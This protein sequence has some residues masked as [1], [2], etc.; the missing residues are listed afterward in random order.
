MNGRTRLQNAT[1]FELAAAADLRRRGWDVE[2][3]GVEL[4]SETAIG[5]LQTTPS[6]VRWLPDLLA[7][8]GP[9]VIGIDAKDSL[10]RD[11]DRHSIERDSI[12]A[13]IAF[14]HYSGLRELFVFPDGCVIRPHTAYR[15]SHPGPPNVHG[16][17]TP[18]R[19]IYCSACVPAADVFGEAS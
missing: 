15:V 7:R 6:A 1:R 5:W 2:L 10:S 8:R 14:E 17:G 11:R 3:F 19:L 18:F 4:L 13:A 12:R 9:D 16:S